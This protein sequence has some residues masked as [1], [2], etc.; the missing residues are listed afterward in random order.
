MTRRVLRAT[1]RINGVPP[2]RN[3]SSSS[4]VA[5]GQAGAASAQDAGA[6]VKKSRCHRTSPV[7]RS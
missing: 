6:G 3:A 7:V 2:T 1:A 5:P 4:V